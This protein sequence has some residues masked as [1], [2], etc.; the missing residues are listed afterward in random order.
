C[1]TVAWPARLSTAFRRELSR[2]SDRQDIGLRRSC[3]LRALLPMSQL[4]EPRPSG[5][6]VIRKLPGVQ[7]V[8]TGSYVPDTV[9][10]NAHLKEAHGFDPEWIVQRTG[11]L[12][13]RRAAPAGGRATPA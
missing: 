10:T 9:I 8:S 7:I 5:R 3:L 6:I 4:S 2:A 13:R 1:V 11:R 12:E